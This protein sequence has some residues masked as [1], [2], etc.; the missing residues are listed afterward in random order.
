[1][2]IKKGAELKEITALL[3]DIEK[4]IKDANFIFQSTSGSPF[5]DQIPTICRQ[6]VIYDLISIHMGINRLMDQNYNELF[7]NQPKRPAAECPVSEPTEGDKAHG[8]DQKNS[9]SGGACP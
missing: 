6:A 7:E 1:M 8:N 3:R 9:D 5:C 2:R 4:S